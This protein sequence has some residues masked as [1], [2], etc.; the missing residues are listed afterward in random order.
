MSNQKRCKASWYGQLFFFNSEIQ[1]EVKISAL[2]LERLVKIKRTPEGQGQTSSIERKISKNT[3]NSADLL[4]CQLVKKRK[5]QG[6]CSIRMQIFCYVISHNVNLYKIIIINIVSFL[7]ANIFLVIHTFIFD[8][9]FLNVCSL[10][11]WN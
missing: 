1:C 11:L 4:I 2:S 6:L 9:S 8:L 3:R 10:L 5:Y 7:Q